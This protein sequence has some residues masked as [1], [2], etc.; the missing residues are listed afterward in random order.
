[1]LNKVY[2][3]TL[4]ILCSLI[5]PQEWDYSADIAEIKT[6]DGV[7]IKK[8]EGNVIINHGNLQL[9]TVQAIEYIKENELHLYGNVKMID[10]DNMI[11]CDTLVYFK[12]SESCLARNNVVL[13]QFDKRVLSDTLFYWDAKDSI[14]ALGN[15]LLKQND[16]GRRILAQEMLMSRPD[17]L[18]Q[19]LNLFDSAQLY[20]MT[21]SRVLEGGPFQSFENK[22]Q[23]NNINVLIYND[24]LQSLDIFG[25][26]I[27]D[28]H[29]V[30]DSL[31][32]G[33]NNIS[34][35]SISMQFINN[36]LNRME[37]F[38]GGLG[39]FT[40]E[41]NNSKVDSI[42]YY[43]ADY[44]DYVI[45]HEN[46]ILNK[47][48]EVEY[49]ETLI[50]AGDIVVNWDTNLLDAK[51]FHGIY[52]LVSI[53]GENPMSGDYMRFD[54]INKKGTINKGK[55]NFDNGYYSGKIIE[56][57]E[58]NIMHMQESTYTSCELDHPHYYFLSE[59]M[60]MLQ[61]DKIIA[62]P[63]TLY[64]SDFPI[65]S[66]PFAILPN[67]GGDR[68]S[69]WIMPSIGNSNKRGTFL[70]NLGYYFAPNDYM[71][72]KFLFSLYDL[73][74][75]NLKSQFRYNKRYEYNG[76][77]KSTL[78]RDLV[79]IGDNTQDITNIFS[80]NV[81]QD[82]DIHWTHQQSF[83]PYQNFNFD[84][85]Y[86]TSNDFY[87][88]EDIG[89][90]LDT[91]LKQKIESS[92]NYSKSWPHQKNSFTLYLSD[93]YDVLSES[94]EPTETPNYYKI[95]TLP[96][97]T[98][99]HNSS[100]LFN[101]GDNWYNNI[102]G[103]MS[104]VFTGNQKVGFYLDNDVKVDTIDYKSGVIN[105][106]NLSMTSKVF[107]WFSLNPNI[108]LKESWVFRYKEYELDDKGNFLGNDFY[109]Y[110][111]DFK[112]RL[113]G[114]LSMS[115]STKLY[116]IIP[117][118]LGFLESIRHVLSPSISYSYTPS[119]LNN[120]QYFQIDNSGNYLDYFS[121][122][123]VGSTPS[124]NTE[125]YSFSLRNDFQIKYLNNLGNPIKENILFW[126]L[127]T[128]FN[129]KATAFNW[130]P[131]ISTI[132]AKIPHL[133]DINIS[134]THDLYK[135]QLN[136]EDNAY[137]ERINS[138]APF[139][140]LT[141]ISA[142]TDL[143]LSGNKFGYDNIIEQDSLDFEAKLDLTQS[144]DPY[145]PIIE[146]GKIWD[147]RLR[148]NYSMY[149][150]QNSNSWDK[151]FWVNSDVDMNISSKWKMTY[152]ARFDMKDYEIVSHSLYLF[153]PLHCWDFSF[154]W[155]PS[156]DN[157][158]FILNIY[159]RNSDLRDVKIKSTGGSF[160]GL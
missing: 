81:T 147:L 159:V 117:F 6:I 160:F 93:S 23:G 24:T 68:R 60:K 9:N 103:S 137:Y 155:W 107:K 44:I 118:K 128:S 102:Y 75:V 96:K 28:Y 57:E 37:V 129:P 126:T 52:P 51:E 115:L 27:T 19:I 22:M 54:L 94:N 63:I 123:L 132:Q 34:G 74:G 97:I 17:S 150:D 35:D 50:E 47:N 106:F 58:P 15:I 119:L 148:F 70:Q 122:S 56:R 21:Q 59:K 98:F 78:K 110:K 36:N 26:A 67:K 25:M 38:G 13:N 130:S 131:I 48:A 11:E 87:T 72:L 100:R 18:T 33:M 80:N 40:P 144:N 136:I 41:G 82:W 84:L 2:T 10:G 83:D 141:S 133:F 140:R 139:P 90:D 89:L 88:S 101:D 77:I 109:H 4:L 20:S 112:R 7:K 105:N 1:M 30:R 91:R 8:F 39:Q 53:A 62:K 3:L 116:G 121:G 138:F 42:V 146:S 32:M 113:S 142:S 92:L 99:R 95:R 5:I 61:G 64:I 154:K 120:R 79:Q 31:L 69:G 73:K 43:K 14:K 114:S 135:R 134:M 65:I 12:D 29:V 71:D 151:T 16:T 46:T 85:T 152:S 145:E 157:K 153:R 127:N 86:I 76:N 108:S 49:K 125:K 45:D 66:F 55:T 143:A 156:G 158:G 111:E 124:S 149:Q 104:S